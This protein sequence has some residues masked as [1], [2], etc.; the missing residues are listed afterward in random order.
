MSITRS[1]TFSL[2]PCLRG[3]TFLVPIRS[4]PGR[5]PGCV[6]W[7]RHAS[8]I[9]DR[10]PGLRFSPVQLR[11]ALF[12]AA[13]FQTIGIYV[14]FLA[15]YLAAKGLSAGQV[16]LLLGA[17]QLS[18]LIGNPLIARAADL[19]GEARWPL[20]LAS[21]ASLLCFALFFVTSGFAAL[22]VLCLVL[23]LVFTAVAPLADS[24]AVPAAAAGGFDYGRV[25]LWGS[26]SFILAASLGGVAIGRFGTGATMWLMLGAWALTLAAAFGLPRGA[27]RPAGESGMLSLLADPAFLAMLAIS[28]SIQASHALLYGFGTI[29]W[30]AAGHSPAT[31]GWLWALAV[32]SEVSLFWAGKRLLRRMSGPQLFVL[33]GAGAV[34][35]W[36]L[37]ALGTALPLLMAVQALHGFSFA[38]THLAAMTF[39]AR[40]TPPG[41]TVTA[42][43]LQ[44]IAV[45]AATGVVTL[46]SGGL[47]AALG[48]GG[49]YVMAAVA[50]LGL[51]LALKASR[52]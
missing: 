38:A 45:G 17:L 48:G 50:A 51:G 12:Y 14:P 3:E 41:L 13:F 7:R 18:R 34:L 6:A 24:L 10:S 44:S 4:V 11:L 20:I 32:L 42:Q 1:V 9:A 25:R 21:L 5:L 22:L 47:Y 23:G 29:Q 16:G 33:G 43:V 8:L 52:P 2:P 28:A 36:L 49:Y 31:V 35:R 40:R 30:L 15:N 19:W 26:L 27:R 46:A 37:A 39:L